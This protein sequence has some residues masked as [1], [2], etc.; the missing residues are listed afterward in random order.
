MSNLYEIE[1]QVRS[2]LGERAGFSYHEHKAT[3]RGKRPPIVGQ[4]QSNAL[5][6][7][8]RLFHIIL[9]QKNECCVVVNSLVRFPP[10]TTASCRLSASVLFTALGVTVYSAVQS[11][12]T[13]DLHQAF[14][15]TWRISR[16]ADDFSAGV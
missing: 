7:T 11:R 6:Q 8:E 4:L 2:S 13:G 9:A 10:S 16:P 14:V 1:Y 3:R 5:T 15:S 12:C